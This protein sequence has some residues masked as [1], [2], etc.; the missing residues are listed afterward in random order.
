MLNRRACE[1]RLERIIAGSRQDRSEHVFCFL[2]LDHFKA[3][4]DSCGHLAG[5]DLL[6]GVSEL[7]AKQLRQRDTLARL[8]GDE[9]AIIL[10]HCCLSQAR[11]IG[12][13]I[14]EEIKQYNF[15]WQDHCFKIGVSIGMAKINADSTDFSTVI[16]EADQ[17]CYQVKKQGR[18]QVAVYSKT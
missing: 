4:N 10:E 9:F 15:Y 13:A 17:A 5:D 6:R 11:D 18:G 3:V 12:A 2:D 16:E 1:Q 8:G 14:C 7:L